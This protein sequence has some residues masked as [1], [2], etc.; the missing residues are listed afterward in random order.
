MRRSNILI[1]VGLKIPKGQPDWGMDMTLTKL[2]KKSFVFKESVSEF[3][4]SSLTIVLSVTAALKDKRIWCIYYS[5][6]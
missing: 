1:V 5:Y 6:K 3:P 4:V 2:I